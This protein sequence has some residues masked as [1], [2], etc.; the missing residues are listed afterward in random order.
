MILMYLMTLHGELCGKEAGR[1]K[2]EEYLR[3]E[4]K[5]LALA[6]FDMRIYFERWS[7]L[8]GTIWKTGGGT[9]ED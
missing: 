3:F 7:N 9:L 8:R 2:V 6:V 1:R 5:A 4:L